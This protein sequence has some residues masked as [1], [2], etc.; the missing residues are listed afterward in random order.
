VLFYNRCA[1]FHGFQRRV[2]ETHAA[3]FASISPYLFI[4]PVDFKA[5][6][7]P[8]ACYILSQIATGW[9]GRSEKQ[10]QNYD[11]AL[12]FSALMLATKQLNHPR[13]DGV[14]PKTKSITNLI[15]FHVISYT[16]IWLTYISVSSSRPPNRS[17]L[18]CFCLPLRHI[19][20][21]PPARSPPLRVFTLCLYIKS[22]TKYN[23]FYFQVFNHYWFEIN[24]L[25]C[26]I[27]RN[28]GIWRPLYWRFKCSRTFSSRR[29]S[30]I[31]FSIQFNTIT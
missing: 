12:S 4:A 6:K 9:I 2:L 11:D 7:R 5:D 3:H 31:C 10:K 17:I 1:L 24:Y 21:P 22:S 23:M 16:S 20:V 8:F 27:F 28:A 29:L 26:K 25:V 18:W 13:D 14:P 30:L 15:D 19:Y